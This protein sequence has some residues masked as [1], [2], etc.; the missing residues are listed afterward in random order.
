MADADSPVL[1][2]GGTGFI[3]G[4]VLK[5]LLESGRRV[6]AFDTKELSPEGRFLLGDLAE[7]VHVEQGSIEDWARLL[8]VV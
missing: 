4:Y 8:L 1:V 5:T 7:K 3:G 6:V 2:T